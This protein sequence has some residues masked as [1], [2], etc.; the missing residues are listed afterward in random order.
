MRTIA[1]LLAAL[2]AP[3]RAGAGSIQVATERQ[4]FNSSM[5]QALQAIANGGAP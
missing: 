5:D 2:A 3:H 1:L 4:R